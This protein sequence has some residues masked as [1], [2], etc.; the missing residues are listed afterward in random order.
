MQ[1]AAILDG[2]HALQIGLKAAFVAVSGEAD[3]V[4]ENRCFA[5]D[6]THCHSKFTPFTGLNYRKFARVSQLVVKKLGFIIRAMIENKER[7]RPRALPHF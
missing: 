3:L 4:A 1:L 5:A 2:V 7:P 6:L